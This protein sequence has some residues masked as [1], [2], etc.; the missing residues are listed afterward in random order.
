M[1]IGL[2]SNISQPECRRDIKESRRHEADTPTQITRRPPILHFSSSVRK[3]HVCDRHKVEMIG[4]SFSASIRRKIEGP[5]QKV[6][7]LDSWGEKL[8]IL[9]CIRLLLRHRHWLSPGKNIIKGARGTQALYCSLLQDRLTTTWNARSPW[10]NIKSSTE[11]DS[12][13]AHVGSKSLKVCEFH[14][15]PV[16]E[17]RWWNLWFCLSC[18]FF[19][20]SIQ[21]K[22]VSS[23]SDYRLFVCLLFTSVVVLRAIMSL[24]WV[25]FSGVAYPVLLHLCV[26]STNHQIPPILCF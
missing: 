14:V 13:I 12:W 21:L 22:D 10:K 5:V 4:N 24:R 9:L 8:D 20:E 3:K 25:W 11:G 1:T 2:D 19:Y 18:I 7:E 17:F 16:T 26:V 6:N 23:S 15:S